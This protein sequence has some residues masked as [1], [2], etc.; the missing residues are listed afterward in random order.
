[1]LH[2]ALKLNM[3]FSKLG[4]LT[5]LI[6]LFILNSC[7]NQDGIGLGVDPGSEL[8]GSL[9]VDTSVVIT[10]VPEDTVITSAL[11]RTPLSYFKDPEL[12][13]TEANIAAVISLPGG[14]AYTLPTG[15]LQIDSAVLVLPY[16][17]G[18]YGDSIASKFKLNVHQLTETLTPN[19]VYYNNKQWGINQT[20]LGTKTFTARPHDTI[21]ILNIIKGKPDTLIKVV[22]QIRVAINPDFINAY[23]FEAPASWR[24]SNAVFQNAI[25]GLYLT[26]D[27]AQTTGPGGNIMLTLDSARI[28]VH[29]HAT[30][31]AGVI[32]TAVVTLPFQ[33]TGHAAQIKHTYSAKVQAAITN[34]AGDGNI[35]L[36][37]M[38]GLRAKVAFP[39]V[40]NM[41]SNIGNVVINRAELVVTARPGTTIPY[42]AAQ[43]LT[44]YQF[45]IAKQR[46]NIQDGSTTDPRGQNGPAFFGGFYINT[47]NEYHFVITGY[48][49]DLIQGK[50]VDY[51]TFIAPVNPITTTTVDI[52]Q[53]AQF[54][55]RTIAVGK[56]SPYRIKLNVIYTKINN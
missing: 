11:G 37:P 22:P 25:K 52:A 39:N 38:G 12:G 7:K 14:S 5:L 10:N 42:R 33:A 21:R 45:D 44:M 31:T 6:S 46:I 24:G 27:Q 47:N 43:K 8:N 50:T 49:Q 18:F 53:T 16:A 2:K 26:L 23:L 9:L 32:D 28:N 54:A 4:L 48:L 51:G 19:R 56:N 17:E 15:T 1:M 3:K 34:P 55:E 35:Y 13:T 20:L 41:F 36:K 29:Y 40:K 30:S